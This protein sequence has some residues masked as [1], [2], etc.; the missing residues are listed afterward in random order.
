M[1]T[2]WRRLILLWVSLFWASQFAAQALSQGMPALVAV[3]KDA[4]WTMLETLLT[5]GIEANVVYGDGSSALHWASYHDSVDSAKGLIAAGADVDASTDLGVTPLWLAAENG[6]ADMVK[7][8][9][10]AGADARSTLYSGETLVMTAARSGNADVVGQLL[11]AGANPDAAVTRGQTALMWAAT[12]GHSAVVEALL[13][14]GADTDARTLV[15]S[16]YVKTEKP[17]DSHPAYKSWVELGGNSALM[18]A[19]R[20]GDLRSAQLL[21]NAGSDINAISAFGTSP[22][23]MAV[24]GG[25]AELLAFL[26]D[27][28]ADPDAADSGHTPLHAAILRGNPEAVK[29]L[30]DHGADI[31]AILQRATPVRRQSA[32]YHFHEALI[33]ATPLWLAARVTEP[34]IMELL[35]SHGADALFVKDVS[36]RAQR[37][38]A[39]I[40]AAQ[41]RAGQGRTEQGRVEQENTRPSAENYIAEE[42]EISL[43]MAAVGMGHSRLRNSWGNPDRRAGRVGQDRESFILDASRIALQAGVDLNLKNASS[44]TALGFAR[45]RRYDSVVSLL[46]SAGAKDE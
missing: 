20:S 39:Q 15:R 5:D 46:L 17:Q 14:Y 33:G 35:L 8:L 16:Q 29:V 31:E 1:A 34:E 26:L 2:G 44:Q 27:S 9:L 22:A 7:T 43:L 45:S 42:G 36:Y 18:F 24:H 30:L 11:A 28:G 10:Q 41:R 6:S 37:T 38:A 25:N 40:I 13:Q 12:Q 4:N 21:V 32:D 19:A 3:A 23:V